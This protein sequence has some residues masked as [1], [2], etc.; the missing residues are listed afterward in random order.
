MPLARRPTTKAAGSGADP[1]GI[2]D[3]FLR[4]GA[5]RR[6]VGPSSWLLASNP[7]RLAAH[8]AETVAGLASPLP[9]RTVSSVRGL[10]VSDCLTTPPAERLPLQPPSPLS[11]FFEVLLAFTRLG[12]TSFGG[13][14]A[15]LAYFR[16]EFVHRRHWLDE[17]AY[18]DLVALCQF[19]PGPASSQ[20]GMALGLSRAGLWGALAAWLG[21]TL[22]SAVLL[23]IFALGV[24]TLGDLG[25]AGWLHG[26]KI[27]AVAVVAQAVLG[28]SRSLTPERPR[29][30]LALGSAIAA[31]LLTHALA[32]LLILALSA[33]ATGAPPLPGSPPRCVRAPP[34]PI[35]SV[36]ASAFRARLR[37]PPPWAGCRPPRPAAPHPAPRRSP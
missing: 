4:P 33:G 16:A 25:H 10:P 6:R 28:M 12:L 15:H 34:A 17:H 24:S 7:S 26:L 8:A 32:Q 23:V 36:W 35:G 2:T 14:V 5:A 37:R 27:V 29:A 18:A 9:T 22:P 1:A 11:S 31:L 30:A 13:P 3:R 19:L 20:V 21:F